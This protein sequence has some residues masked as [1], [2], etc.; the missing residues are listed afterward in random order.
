MQNAK[1]K[2]QKWFVAAVLCLICGASSVWAEETASKQRL[3][4]AM[5]HVEDYG[6]KGSGVGAFLE[7]RDLAIDPSGNLLVADTGNHRIVKLNN[8]GAYLTEVGG[9][10]WDDKQF[11]EPTGVSAGAGLDIY[12]SDSQNQRVAVYS[13]HLKLVAIVGGRDTD[14]GLSITRPAGIA[15]T[16]EGELYVTD[17]DLDQVVQISTFSRMDRSFGGY[18]YGSGELRAPTAIDVDP[19]GRVYVCDTENDRVVVFDRYGNYDREIGAEVLVKP[20]GVALGPKGVLFVSDTGAHRVIAFDLAKDEVAGRLGGPKA[21]SSPG[22][23][24]SPR[25]L[26]YGQG[27]HLYVVDSGNHRVSKYK[28]LVLKR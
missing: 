5:R 7:P 11:N 12:V 4:V 3:H 22:R 20:E 17:R 15:V 8:K 13:Q 21:S 14:V 28:T 16:R 10:G 24:H 1:C 19:E 26:T 27:D 6:R 23:F 25:G 18:G 9:F 2:V